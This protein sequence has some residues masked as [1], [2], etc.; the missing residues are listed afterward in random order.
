VWGSYVSSVQ[1]SGEGGE[2]LRR[3]PPLSVHHSLFADPVA[4]A[5]GVGGVAGL[6]CA[7]IATA[8]RGHDPSRLRC[9]RSICPLSTLDLSMHLCVCVD[10]S[11]G[12]PARAGVTSCIVVVLTSFSPYG[13]YYLE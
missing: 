11:T 1:L 9:C 12:G 4:I 7:S 8:T 6:L 10:I 13:Y 5:S 2:A 3:Q